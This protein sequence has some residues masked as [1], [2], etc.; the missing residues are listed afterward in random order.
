MKGVIVYKGK[1][2]ATRQYAQW[3]GNDLKLPVRQPDEISLNYLTNC[4]FIILGSAVY[5]GKLLIWKW[6]KKHAGVLQNKKLFLFIVCGTSSSDKEK[7]A[8]IVKNNVPLSI[9]DQT[10]IY[11]LHGKMNIKELNWL[12]RFLLKMGAR[13][14][15]DPGTKKEM[16]T[17]YNDVKKQNITAL[18]KEVEAFGCN[19]GMPV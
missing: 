4:D 9:L 19:T 8:V 14:E 17:D 3:I 13:L 2:G 5:I 1:Y 7:L 15:K 12:D 10:S 16:L 11:F 18:V 6:L